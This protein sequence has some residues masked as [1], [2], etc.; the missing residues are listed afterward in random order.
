MIMQRINYHTYI[1][2]NDSTENYILSE[3]KEI[4]KII[5]KE[6]ELPLHDHNDLYFTQEETNVLL[7][8]KSEIGH[9]HDNRYYSKKQ[10]IEVVNGLIDQNKA[11]D[12]IAI[13]PKK[14]VTNPKLWFKVLE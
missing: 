2:V 1:K 14:P 12:E 8:K 5:N 3:I 11:E 9:N 10:V 6:Q 4:N 13:S 7:S